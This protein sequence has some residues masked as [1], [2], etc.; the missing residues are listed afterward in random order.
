[1]SV[2]QNLCKD[3]DATRRSKSQKYKKPHKNVPRLRIP[4][5]CCFNLASTTTRVT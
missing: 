1:M 4:V 2:F 3:R 5:S